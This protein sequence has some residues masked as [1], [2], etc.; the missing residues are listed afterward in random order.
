MALTQ[1]IAVN[2]MQLF[3]LRLLGRMQGL[4]RETRDGVC[5]LPVAL[6]LLPEDVSDARA[7]SS[8]GSASKALGPKIVTA[9]GATTPPNRIHFAGADL[10]RCFGPVD[11]EAA[12]LLDFFLPGWAAVGGRD[13]GKGL[14]FNSR[15]LDGFRQSLRA[16]GV[17]RLSG[18]SEL[19]LLD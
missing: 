17:T 19:I 14:L 8:A 3:K 1:A 13:A 12:N 9:P 15:T 11:F 7:P 10:A 2:G 6:L 5:V 4:S 18:G 16:A